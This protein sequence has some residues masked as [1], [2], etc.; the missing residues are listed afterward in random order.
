V[1]MWA[2]VGVPKFRVMS[3]GVCDGFHQILS[4]YFL[5]SFSKFAPLIHFRQL[6]CLY[7]LSI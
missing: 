4:D 1:V 6:R 3:D 7:S 2:C 5:F